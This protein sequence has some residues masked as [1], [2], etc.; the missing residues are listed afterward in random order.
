MHRSEAT[1]CEGEREE[2]QQL[3]RYTQMDVLF[4]GIS[5]EIYLL[6]PCVFENL[7]SS[8]KSSLFYI[9]DAAA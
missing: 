3:W 7:I 8:F 5:S 6:T 4:Y 9:M 2:I 1:R